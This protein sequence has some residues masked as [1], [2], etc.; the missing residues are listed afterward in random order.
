MEEKK[1]SLEYK[2]KYELYRHHAWA[3]LGLLT[4]FLATRYFYPTLPL[5]ISLPIVSGLIIYILISLMGTY[6]YR[7]GLLIQDDISQ[8]NPVST[9][10]SLEIKKEKEQA[11]IEKKRLKAKV[12]EVKKMKK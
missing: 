3:G 6:R 8:A 2:K 5:W 10:E 7:T 1:K 12:K 11:K 9:T 4:V